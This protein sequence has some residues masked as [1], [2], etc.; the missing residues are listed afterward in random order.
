[1]TT[2]LM[3]QLDA[4]L[5]EYLHKSLNASSRSEYIFGVRTPSKFDLEKNLT[6]DLKTFKRIALM[7]NDK[8][9]LKMVNFQLTQ[10]RERLDAIIDSDDIGELE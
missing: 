4:H 6:Q 1:M 2:K 10:Q 8:E 3:K 7:R 9:V 5:D